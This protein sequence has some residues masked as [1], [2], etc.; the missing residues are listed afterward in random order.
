MPYIKI[1]ETSD[2]SKFRDACAILRRE[3]IKFEILYEYRLYSE[4]R[5]D[6]ISGA[7][8]II[9]V[10]RSAYHDAERLLTEYGLKEIVDDSRNQFTMIKSLDKFLIRIPLISNT[11]IYTKLLL[12]L[13]IVGVSLFL[14]IRLKHDGQFLDFDT[15]HNHF[16]VKSIHFRGEE[17]I[18]N[19]K[20][21][22]DLPGVTNW[23]SVFF[24]STV[25]EVNLPGFNSKNINAKWLLIEDKVIQIYDAD[26]YEDL[27]NGTYLI[28]SSFWT[29]DITLVSNV[30]RIVLKR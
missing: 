3:D 17:L 8:A 9:R 29:N 23:E 26:N 19:T 4:K 30:T 16:E 20:H 6:P 12:L 11:P 28:K 1:I 14:L 15:V 18:P 7:G 24:R 10:P 22:I 5:H 21:A 25:N 13:L 2:K 27:Y